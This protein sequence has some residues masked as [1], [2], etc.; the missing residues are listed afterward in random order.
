[1]KKIVFSMVTFLML[2]ASACIAE[3]SQET[4]KEVAQSEQTND[5]KRSKKHAKHENA[6]SQKVQGDDEQEIASDRCHKKVEINKNEVTF[7]MQTQHF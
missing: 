2:G 7:S 4:K 1:M 3:T 5:W 6:E